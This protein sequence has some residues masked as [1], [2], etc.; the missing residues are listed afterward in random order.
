MNF[1]FGIITVEGNIQSVINSIENQNIEN[2][3]I[4]VVG[5][6]N[7]YNKTYIKHIEFDEK[8]KSMWISKKKN[9]ITE[10][11]NFELI[12]YMHDYIKLDN[13]WYNGFNEFGY[14][15]DICMTKILNFDGTRYRDW[16][17]WKDDA[18][19][20]YDHNDRLLLP[21]DITHLSKM[22][23]ISGAYWV[24]KKHIMQKFKLNEHL[25]WNQGEDVE[26]SIRVR[27]DYNFSM[28]TNSS[29]SLLKYK[30]GVS[31]LVSESDLCILKNTHDYDRNDETY[32]KLLYNHNLINWMTK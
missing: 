4:I 1:T 19:N 24:A 2:F 28:N 23:Y 14:N 17:L 25:S 13:N 20:I 9:L 11:S 21:Y 8:I 7:H 22:M 18:K 10:N 30:G 29:V 5:G 3:E 32:H 12:V 26:W 27:K 16:I 31:N 15:W 6:P